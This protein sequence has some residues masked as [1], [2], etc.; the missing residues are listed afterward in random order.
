MRTRARV[1]CG[2]AR[3]ALG[4]A[5]DAL[6]ATEVPELVRERAMASRALEAELVP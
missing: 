2:A 6:G 5:V 4:V 3:G 1:A